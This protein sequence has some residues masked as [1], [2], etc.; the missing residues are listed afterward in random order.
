MYPAAASASGLHS[1]SDLPSA[2]TVDGTS[3]NVSGTSYGD[4]INGVILEGNVWA[5][6]QNS[7][8]STRPCLIQS[9]VVDQFADSY[10]LS[11]TNI[12]FPDES[13]SN[14]AVNRQSLCLWTGSSG[15]RTFSLVYSER[16]QDNIKDVWFVG[17]SGIDGTAASGDRLNTPVG[18]YNNRFNFSSIAIS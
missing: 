11:A 6:Y 5:K 15:D 3:F 13:F 17:F 10:F 16:T 9:G 1:A 4:A 14:V 7:V 12:N 18:G 2:V 8:R